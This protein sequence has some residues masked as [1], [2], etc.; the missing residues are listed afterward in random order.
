MTSAEFQLKDAQVN[1]QRA[2][3]TLALGNLADQ[4]LLTQA[5]SAVESAQVDFEIRAAIF[6]RCRITS[7]LAG[8]ADRVDLVPGQVVGVG[9]PLTR[10]L[11]LDPIHVRLDLP[12]ERIDDIRI[13]QRADVVVDSFP[14]DTFAGTVI[15]IAPLVNQQLR[16]LPLVVEI[17]NPQQRIKAGWTCPAPLN[18]A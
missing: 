11:K 18:G 14:K 7:P 6:E 12:Q 5:L 9:I 1:L 4:A 10:I 2:D 15:R 8:F 16:V 3:N 17:P 13:G